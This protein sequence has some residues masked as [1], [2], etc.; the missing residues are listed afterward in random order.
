MNYG[1]RVYDET[2]LPVFDTTTN[3]GIIHRLL[4]TGA[5]NG[6]YTLP[7]SAG[8]L[9]V[10]AGI[11]RVYYVP[12]AYE[13]CFPAVTV[14]GRTVFWAYYPERWQTRANVKILIGTF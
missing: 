7:T 9:N 10:F 1:L 2:G 8:G 5:V 3:L 6:S 14:S 11:S 13:S 12:T 4:T